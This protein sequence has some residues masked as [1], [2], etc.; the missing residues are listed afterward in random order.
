[1]DRWRRW[2]GD[3]DY[4]L[5]LREYPLALADAGLI[6]EPGQ[7]QE[8]AT[9]VARS[10]IKEQLLAALED[11]VRIAYFR[12]QDDLSSRLLAVARRAD[13]DPWSDQVRD[14]ALWKDR[15]AFLELAE[16]ARKEPDRFSRLTPQTL[17]L[18]GWLLPDRAQE[19][20]LRKA[21]ALHP[22]DFWI[23]YNLAAHL[24]NSKGRPHEAIGF[25]RAALAIRPQ[26]TAVY[27]NLGNALSHDKDLPGAID[28]FKKALA[29]DSQF[30]FAWNNLGIALRIQGD[31]PGAIR[32]Y[33]KALAIDPRNTLAWNNLGFA[34][35]QQND[36][37]AAIDAYK[38][39]LAIDPRYV[40]AWFKL[41]H[42]LRENKDLAG[43]I[44][45]YRKVVE[46][47]P[48]NANAFYALG[49]VLTE[50]KE[51]EEAVVAYH[52]VIELNPKNAVVHVN[53][54]HALRDLKKLDDA[55]AA[56]REA[57][58]LEPDNADW[59]NWLGI[60][61]FQRDK[62][63]EA[64]AEYRQVIKLKPDYAAA[65]YNLFLALQRQ[66]KIGEAIVAFE[67]V[68]E[69]EPKHALRLNELAWLLATC[70]EAKYRDPKWAVELAKRAVE[71]KPQEGN[72]WNTL[73]VA[74][75]RAGSWK[76]AVAG[77]DRS[78]ALRKGGDAYDWFFLAMAHWKLDDKD[79][80]A[81]W[82]KLAVE[83]MERKK[84]TS[85]MMRQVRAEAAELLA[86]EN[87]KD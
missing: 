47:E 72:Y 77:L 42:A 62:V 46:L 87:K 23:N 79:E 36:L 37:P 69:L 83:W 65:H 24:Q 81:R 7:E 16:Q 51:L 15:K 82:Y 25:Y 48:N 30:G 26:S 1:M 43:A 41:A 55:I 9:R 5:A 68:I 32:A 33:H 85:A 64:I 39:A 53:L 28:A 29:I 67:K 71:L 2:G 22:A 11:W 49:F 8:M 86:V 76:D 3:F 13:P 34:L 52:K 38:K 54:G 14:P 12:R 6:L 56:Y 59:R 21:Q 19:M 70:P 74:H 20:W 27:N 73:G 50:H 78:M 58:R 18:I 60:A 4:A 75:Y 84:A 31:L 35:H 57:V 40:G 63:D 80:A 66:G 61:L 45:A 17:I 44:A 10:P